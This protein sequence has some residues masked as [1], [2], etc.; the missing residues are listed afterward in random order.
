MYRC[1]VEYYLQSKQSTIA[2]E[3]RYI[4]AALKPWLQPTHQ[5]DV[6]LRCNI[7]NSKSSFMHGML[8]SERYIIVF[9][10]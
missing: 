8:S 4:M 3:C 6:N 5:T 7:E 9:I 2:G 1:V 10:I